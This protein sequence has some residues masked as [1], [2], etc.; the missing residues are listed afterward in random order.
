MAVQTLVS[1]IFEAAARARG[2]A[3]NGPYSTDY[4]QICWWSVE[5]KCNQ[6]HIAYVKSDFI[7]FQSDSGQIIAN[8]KRLTT[9][10]VLDL[11]EALR[12]LFNDWAQGAG[13]EPTNTG[14]RRGIAKRAGD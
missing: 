3:G 13:Y 10:G 6:Q 8:S 11:P 9:N 5:Y 1:F 14:R 4:E 2:R 7:H 12:D